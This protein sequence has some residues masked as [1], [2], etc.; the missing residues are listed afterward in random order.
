MAL[1]R[2]SSSQG[3]NLSL[4]MLN[5]YE[6]Y[7]T[8]EGAP[9]CVAGSMHAGW[10][11]HADRAVL[12]DRDGQARGVLRPPPGKNFCGALFRVGPDQVLALVRY[13]QH[14]TCALALYRMRVL[15]DLASCDPPTAK[16]TRT[17]ELR[18]LLGLSSD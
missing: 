17:A 1:L 5:D 4:E 6:D 7:A 9:V 18:D 2:Y 3:V 12:L 11:V 14:G 8:Q 13:G 10:L 16:P 15:A